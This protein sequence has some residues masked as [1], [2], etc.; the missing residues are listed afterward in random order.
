MD[1]ETR[2]GNM[3]LFLH[4]CVLFLSFQHKFR[5]LP[6][7][8]MTVNNRRCV[9]ARSEIKLNGGRR[10]LQVSTLHSVIDLYCIEMCLPFRVILYLSSPFATLCS[11]LLTH[12][13]FLSPSTLPPSPLPLLLKG[14]FVS[15][16]N[17]K[18]ITRILAEKYEPDFVLKR[19]FNLEPL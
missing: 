9:H 6:G 7:Q 13:H 14:T 16:D 8:T 10:S 18:S 11:F 3:L 4:M 2:T 15:S 1:K 12:T 5:L 19:T 17:L